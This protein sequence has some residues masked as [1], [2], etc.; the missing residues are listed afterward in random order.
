[1]LQIAKGKFFTSAKCYETTHRGTYYTNYRTLSPTPIPIAI[2]AILPSTEMSGIG[3]LTY[4]LL[5]KIEWMEPA[6]GVMTST[7]G[8][9]LVEEVAA[10]L[11]FALDVICT[12]DPDLTRRL[13]GQNGNELNQLNNPSKFI[14]RV[15]DTRVIA[16]EEDAQ[17]T[18][19][20]MA[21]LVASERK[22]YEPSIRAIRRYVTA[23]HRIADDPS[24]AY[25]LL[26]MSME[27]LAQADDTPKAQWSDYEYAKRKRIDGALD[28]APSE[29]IDA[30]KRAILE[31][32][33]VAI[34]RRFREFVISHVTP[35]FFRQEA[36]GASNPIT[37]PDLSILIRNAYATR[38][39]YVHLLQDLPKLLETPF[40]FTEVAVIE[41]QPTLTFQ[42]LARLTR[43]VIFRFVQQAP[44][45]E[46][47][48]Y[49]WNSA[50]PNVIR[51]QLAPELW[52]G[53][54]EGYNALTAPLWLENFLGQYSAILLG[55]PNA[56][57]SNLTP[58][59]DKIES[60]S[61]EGV[62]AKQRRA[63]I[64]LYHLFTFVA[65]PAYAR[66]RHDELWERNEAEFEQPT[67][68]GIALCLVHGQPI[69]WEVDSLEILYKTYYDERRRK[70]A[71]MLSPL[72]EAMFTLFLAEMNRVSGNEL[73]ARDL[74]SFAVESSPSDQNLR[75]YES[76]LAED[77]LE[78]I[79]PWRILLPKQ[80]R[81]L[82]DGPG[83]SEAKG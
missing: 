3:T 4:E 59:L 48:Q 49:D 6:P 73:R 75:Q 29:I 20:F 81:A 15:F 51:L 13:S 32:E 45:M 2:G 10:V 9:E 5:E 8:R 1:M 71:M 35:A 28:G 83:P 42:G 39:G 37:R 23:M 67:I 33:H 21:A 19:D 74:I 66:L 61:F 34:A 27:S 18:A 31:N 7:G 41:G 36:M 16:Q 38:S 43:H 52:M 54:A 60:M 57:L 26:I 30:V 12:T 11:S 14:G 82:T 64:A 40:N 63:I 65:G 47:E 76:G 80:E 24:L 78:P 17:R 69:P 79:D 77:Q 68:E 25:A 62:K 44:K 46:S 70:G 55:I 22:C 56:A 50:L 53:N 58:I 72:F